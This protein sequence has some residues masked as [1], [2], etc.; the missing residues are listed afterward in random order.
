MKTLSIKYDDLHDFMEWTQK[1]S[2]L[3]FD[4]SNSV[5]SFP[6]IPNC[7]YWAYMG[8]N[9][10]SEEGKHRPVLITRTYKNSPICTVIPLT[11]QRLND[12]YW[13]HIDLEHYNS[14]VL[15]EQMRIIDIT[16][17]DKPYRIKGKI[18]SIS[19][20]DWESISKEVN[21]LYKLQ[22]KPEN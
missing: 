18:S 14:T 2:E 8:C 22:N 5:K 20:K 4:T 15:C 10:G 1:K 7:I 12:E 21:W 16:R 17:I 6:I 11:T 19:K 3:K 9:V 13:Y